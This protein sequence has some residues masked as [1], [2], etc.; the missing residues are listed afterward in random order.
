M[1]IAYNI[2]DKPLL[3]CHRGYHKEAPENSLA[4]F[5]LVLE[6]NFKAIET[7]IHVCK[8]GELVIMHDFN[9][10]RMT[11][12]DKDIREL[13]LEQI[14]EIN[15]AV[16]SDSKFKNQKIPTL[17]ELF[18]LCKKDV[19]YDLE[20]KSNTF[21]NR[22]IAKKTWQLIQEYNMEYNVI[23]SSFNPLAI[24]SFESISNNGIQSAIIYSEGEG[25]PF[26]LKHGFGASLCNCTILKPE[27]TQLT[28]K[29]ARKAKEH[30]YKFLPWCVDT[31]EE[32]K[33]LT[34]YNIIGMISNRVDIISKTGL[35]Y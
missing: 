27:Y 8:S 19:V 26:P 1:S 17:R 9:L 35:F 32:A 3:F 6:N 11:G 21:E 18:E 10:K 28:P 29:T 24:R 12:I 34:N 14:K 13:T 20:L 23:V 15:I 22:K 2:N 25:V 4:A 33:C 7:D 5:E 31:I 30:N 16:D